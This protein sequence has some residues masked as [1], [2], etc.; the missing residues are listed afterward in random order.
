MFK[1][2]TGKEGNKIASLILFLI[3]HYLTCSPGGCS[4]FLALEITAPN[5]DTQKKEYFNEESGN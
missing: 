2:S 1:L 4:Q 3:L 5:G